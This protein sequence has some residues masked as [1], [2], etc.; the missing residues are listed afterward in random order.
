MMRVIQLAVMYVAVLVFSAGQVR[1]AII[2]PDAFGYTASNEV[3][4]V[5]EDIS[6]TGTNLGL[7]DDSY[8][9][10]INSGTFN[11]QFYGNSYSTFAVGSNG[12]VYFE[13]NYLGLS[14]KPIPGPTGYTP[15]RFIAIYW[16]DLNPGAGGSVLY[17]FL[18]SGA[19]E[20][21]VVQWQSVPHYFSSDPVTAQATLFQNGDI[22]LSYLNPSSRAGSGATVGIQ[23]D[24]SLGLQWSH[25][26]PILTAGESILFSVPEP[27]S[28]AMFGIGACVAGL[29]AARRRRR[30]KKQGATA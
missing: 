6:A 18:G 7:T 21:L 4:F 16:D 25:N 2:G 9:Y 10:G 14:N 27:S 24:P 17:E 1:A 12:T 22:R 3:P 15:A 26:Q 29:G 5:F 19:S 30:E 13:N 28:L 11:F 8:F 23:N 20:R